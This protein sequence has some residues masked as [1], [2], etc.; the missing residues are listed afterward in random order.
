MIHIRQRDA[1][2]DAFWLPDRARTAETERRLTAGCLA[3]LSPRLGD[4][5]EELTG[6]PMAE[7]CCRDQHQYDR[8]D[9]ERISVLYGPVSGFLS[10]SDG[11][12]AECILL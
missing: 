3:D 10:R 6:L 7:H 4:Y 12:T 8:S 1:E 2:G 5:Q 11:D 9:H